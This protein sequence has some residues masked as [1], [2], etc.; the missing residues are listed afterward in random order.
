MTKD[1]PDEGISEVSNEKSINELG[2]NYP[3]IFIDDPK[4]IK[5]WLSL[6]DPPGYF[7][8]KIPR[9]EDLDE[10]ST[11]DIRVTV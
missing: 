10:D 3:P 1:P 4:P 6:L 9:F 8:F 11:D 7:S 2:Y 5:I